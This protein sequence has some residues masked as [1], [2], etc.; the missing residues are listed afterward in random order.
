MGKDYRCFKTERQML[1]SGEMGDV[2]VETEDFTKGDTKKIPL[3]DIPMMSDERW[4]QLA[5]E[6]GGET[7]GK[8][9]HQTC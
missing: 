6:M 3:L 5:A 7:D 8:D 2:L 9:Q 4:N 1:P